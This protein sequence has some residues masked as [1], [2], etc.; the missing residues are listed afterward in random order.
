MICDL[1]KV[2]LR[3]CVVTRPARRDRWHIAA[4]DAGLSPIM[5]IDSDQ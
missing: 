2:S 1:W 3:E 4:Y 5:L